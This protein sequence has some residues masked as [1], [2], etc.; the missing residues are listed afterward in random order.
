VTEK[1]LIKEQALSN[2]IISLKEDGGKLESFSRRRHT[3]FARSDNDS[4]TASESNNQT[5][6]PGKQTAG[7]D[8]LQSVVEKY[9]GA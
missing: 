2:T 6:R 1:G 5:A 7:V 9:L 8:A 3:Y 4:T